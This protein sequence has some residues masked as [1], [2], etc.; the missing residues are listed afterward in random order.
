MVPSTRRGRGFTIAR[1]I[2]WVASCRGPKTGTLRK[3]RLGDG[4]RGQPLP[5]TSAG[6]RRSDHARTKLEGEVALGLA[7]FND[8]VNALPAGDAHLSFPCCSIQSR[9][10]KNRSSGVA[11]PSTPSHRNRFA[12]RIRGV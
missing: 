6:L 12:R 7:A 1:S 5:V 11:R 4:H 10:Q 9:T 3:K 8:D 2:G